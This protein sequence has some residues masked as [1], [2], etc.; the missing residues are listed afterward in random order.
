MQAAAGRVVQVSI[1]PGGVPKLPVERAWVG[2]FGL[3]G[4]GHSE[5]TVHGGPHRAVCLFALEVIERLQAE[6]HPIT[7]GGAGENLTTEG[8]EWSLLPVGTRARIGATLELELSSSTTPCAT[9]TAN[10]RDGNFNRMLIDRHPADSRMY[11]RVVT[12]GEVRPGDSISIMPPPDGSRAADEVLLRR[13]DRAETK[14]SVAAW[15]AARDAGFEIELFEDGELA[16]SAAPEIPGPAFN[17]ASGL[18]RLPNLLSLATDFYD[19]RGTTGYL[20]LEDPPW[21]DAE[22]SLVVDIFAAEAADVAQEEPADGVVI[23]RVGPD[24]AEAFTAV[25][26]GNATAGGIARGG[27]NPWPAVYQQLARTNS[28]QLYL[29]ELNGRPVANATLHISARTGWL[30]GALVAPEAR[31]RGIQRAMITARVRAAMEAG[32]DL[33]GASAEPAEVSSANLQRMG[34]RR[35]GRR[36][37]YIYEPRRHAP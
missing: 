5:P 32:C 17:Q 31:G 37:S 34:L 15:R 35:I 26:S 1:S 16:M 4:D 8:V 10:F 33:V 25:R 3:D 9:Q 7:A 29:A 12:E 23:R 28:R 30:R 13:L 20:W 24:E 6:G 18:A 11:A 27:P 21:L 36:S 19:R 14:S 22:V 2:R